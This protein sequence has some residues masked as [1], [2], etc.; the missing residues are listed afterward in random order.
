M[1]LKSFV[2]IVQICYQKK[3]K[4]EWY[5]ISECIIIIIDSKSQISKYKINCYWCFRQ[6]TPKALNGFENEINCVICYNSN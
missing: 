1:Q 6:H 3:E 5:C 2:C 4:D